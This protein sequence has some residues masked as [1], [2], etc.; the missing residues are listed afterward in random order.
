[1]PWAKSGQKVPSPTALP[2]L[3]AAG[4]AVFFT[5]LLISA[6]LVLAIGVI[7]GLAG[8]VAW[9]WRTEADLR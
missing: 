6:V 5:G 3:I 7:V 2:L 9:T 4:L 1:M 8:L